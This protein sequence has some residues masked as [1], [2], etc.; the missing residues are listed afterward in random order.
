MQPRKNITKRSIYRL[1]MMLFMLAPIQ[2]NAAKLDATCEK[3]W[4]ID[5]GSVLGN[6]G[7]MNAEMLSQWKKRES[8]CSGTSVYWARLALVQ[9]GLNELNAAKISIAKAP[10]DGGSYGFVLDMAKAQLVVQERIN[11]RDPLT[12]SD[13]RKFARLYANIVNQY[14]QWPTGHA[15]YG[16]ML[17]LVGNHNDAIKHLQI[18]K[19]GD[20]YQLQS[21]FRSLTISLSAV[22]WHEKALDAA[23][24]AIVRNR[25]LTGDP[26]FAYAVAIS[27]AALGYIEDAEDTLKVILHKRP[28]VKNDQAFLDAV[29]FCR[30]AKIGRT[31]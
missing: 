11:L 15:M 25:G 3:H 29:E 5:S 20:A 12:E 30:K 7:S 17:T 8:E 2:G 22:G 18:A 23:D 4:I 1:A 13:I 19:T 6:V 31:R 9:I 27:H 26:Q 14:P 16:N 24:N 10:T 28:D 21:V